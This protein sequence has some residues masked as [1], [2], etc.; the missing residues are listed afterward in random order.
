[1]KKN[2]LAVVGT[3]LRQFLFINTSKLSKL[4]IY[5]NNMIISKNKDWNKASR[6]VHA[7]KREIIYSRCSLRAAFC[8]SVLTCAVSLEI[9]IE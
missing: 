9:L 2:V 8:A 5:V 3:G 6:T 4:L 7:I 1:M